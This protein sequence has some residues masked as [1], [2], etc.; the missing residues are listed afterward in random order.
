[1]EENR[2]DVKNERTRLKDLKM[3]V[4]E[5]LHSVP[6]D[7]VISIDFSSKSRSSR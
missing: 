3:K 4:E 2:S 5:S 7:F 1:M 6:A